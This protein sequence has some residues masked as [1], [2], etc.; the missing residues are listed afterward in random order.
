ML[1]LSKNGNSVYILYGARNYASGK[2]VTAEIRDN[3]NNTI[4]GSPFTLTEI[5]ANTGLYGTT[6][7][8]TANGEY[9]IKITQ[10]AKDRA[11]AS[12]KITN[13]DIESV[14]G[15]VVSIESTV[16]SVVHG[17]AALKTKLDGMEGSGFATGSDSLKAIK[18]Y[19]VNTI[20]TS[21]SQIQNNVSISVSLSTQMLRPSTGSVSFQ[22]FVDLYDN[23]GNLEDPDDQDS[24]NGAWVSV[25]VTDE[26]GNDRTGNLSGL[27]GGT[28][29]GGLKWM[30][31]NAQ[32]RFQCAYD[33][34]NTHDLE[35]LNFAFDFEEGGVP[36]G[37]RRSSVVT[38]S[39]DL[40]GTVDNIYNEV[41]DV[42]YGLSAIKTL[43][44]TYQTANQADLTNIETKIDT[45]D[46]VV[47]NNYSEL[48]N[49]TYGLS[50][51]QVLIAGIDTDLTTIEGKIDTA[52][53]DLT[54]IKGAGF[55]G[56]EDSLEA[57]SDAIAAIDEQAG[58]YLN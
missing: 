47:D 57:I 48:T 19:L 18:D 38:G 2:T 42:T 29:H 24:P 54:A 46:T 4:V 22:I 33:V 7:T 49:V 5:A 3:A 13:H 50:A 43:M 9:K 39:A 28:T 6:F 41:T 23:T 21:I 14:G 25:D 26:S 53:A 36:K 58:G 32:G 45:V 27:N 37:T 30:T 12:I 20:Q 34:A 35:Q 40:S 8:P 17:N 52:Q 15:D 56:A 44:D 55:N 31:R 11:H 10:G 51:L 16:N 1:N